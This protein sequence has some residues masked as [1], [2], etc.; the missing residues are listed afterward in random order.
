MGAGLG[1]TPY[2]SGD[3]NYYVHEARRGSNSTFANGPFIMAGIELQLL[4]E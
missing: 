2:R 4:G 3:Y 1:G